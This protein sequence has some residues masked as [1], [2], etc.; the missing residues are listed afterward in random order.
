MSG[1][2]GKNDAADAAAI[3]E[4]VAR[5]AMR[6]VPVKTIEQ[7]SELFLHRARQGY[8]E[9]RTALINR[10]RGLLAELGI[11][12]AQKADTVRRELAH[13][14]EDLPGSCNIVVADAITDLERLDAR[15]AEYDRHI[16]GC[17][18]ANADARRLMQLSGIGPTTASALVATVGDGHDFASGRQFAAWLG[19]V[20]GQYSSGG[21]QR[22][23]RITKAGD[24]YLRTLLSLGARSVLQ[25]G[26]K[27]EDAISR[28]TRDVEGR[29]GYW[30]AVVAMAAKNARLAWAVLRRGDDFRLY[31]QEAAAGA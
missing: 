3:C 14:L 7:Q 10:V 22:L 23:G 19:M 5:P 27:K 8:V 15:I 9:Q 24:R 17:A 6:F 12:L 21:K 1:K 25:S 31:G 11:V 13:L 30:K 4:A 28:W 18:K 2:R 16:A 26:R 20:P 29:R